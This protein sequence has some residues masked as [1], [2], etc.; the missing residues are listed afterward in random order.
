VC[1]AR[2]LRDERREDEHGVLRHVGG[3]EDR[4]EAD[5]PHVARRSEARI[6]REL[7][8]ADRAGASSGQRH[9]TTT[10]ATTASV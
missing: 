4:L 5:H 9:D 1:L 2:V 8:D 3:R 10:T 6:R 7:V